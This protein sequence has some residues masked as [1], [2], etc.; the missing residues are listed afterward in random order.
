MTYRLLATMLL[1]GCLTGP[2]LTGATSLVGSALPLKP[3]PLRR[4]K[5]TS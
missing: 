3:P 5:M 2:D 4:P 1:Y